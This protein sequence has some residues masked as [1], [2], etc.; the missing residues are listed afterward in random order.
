M[1]EFFVTCLSDLLVKN[2]IASISNSSIDC[3]ISSNEDILLKPISTTLV[4]SGL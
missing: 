2:S 4:S 3:L 1:T